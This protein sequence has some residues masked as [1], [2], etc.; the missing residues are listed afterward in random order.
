M[1]LINLLLTIL[2]LVLIFGLIYWALQ[3]VPLPP[4]A[5]NI[6]NVIFVVVVVLVMVSM[7]FGG[8]SFPGL[9]VG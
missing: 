8:V 9:R 7:L 2:I 5:R 6:V 1:S 4:P 3:M